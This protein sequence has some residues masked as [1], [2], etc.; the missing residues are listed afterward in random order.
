MSW[1]EIK[2]ALNSSLGTEK[3]MS[4]DRLY[5]NGK[6]LYVSDTQYQNINFNESKRIEKKSTSTDGPNFISLVT[7]NAIQFSIPGTVTIK[8]NSVI[9][10]GNYVSSVTTDADHRVYIYIN[11]TVYKTIY[12]GTTEN[13]TWTFENVPVQSGDKI[14]FKI[15]HRFNYTFSYI[16]LTVTD[17]QVYGEVRESLQI[18]KIHSEVNE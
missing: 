18:E 6:Q 16:E 10:K 3:F 1:G 7:T 15:Q 14:N 17:V 12:D 8:L 5:L 4:L 13:K 9:E 11:D 2:H